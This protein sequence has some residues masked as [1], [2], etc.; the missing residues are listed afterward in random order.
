MAHDQNNWLR[1]GDWVSGRTV[2][3]EMFIGYVESY[4][5]VNGSVKVTVT[6]C[7]H[8]S[9]VH[10]KI[11]TFQ[12]LVKRLPVFD[13]ME[14][15]QLLNMVDIALMEKDRETFMLLT[16]RLRE[17]DNNHQQDPVGAA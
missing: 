4:E 14:R 3:D 10:K 12:N 2:N 11:V 5:E 6:E 15:G 7:D 1:V 17:T 9:L 16:K 8:S 13:L